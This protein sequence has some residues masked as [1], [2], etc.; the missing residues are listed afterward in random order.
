M[1]LI[2]PIGSMYAIYGNIYHPYTPNVSIYIP[3]MDPMG[4]MYINMYS[5]QCSCHKMFI[6]FCFAC[7]HGIQHLYTYGFWS[8]YTQIYLFYIYIIYLSIINSQDTEKDAS[9]IAN[10]GAVFVCFQVEIRPSRRA[11]ANR[12]CHEL[13]K[14]LLTVCILLTWRIGMA[15]S[16]ATAILLSLNLIFGATAAQE[17]PC[18]HSKLY[19]YIY[20]I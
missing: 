18:W 1:I 9:S 5:S 11:S 8:E 4:M 2:Y 12:R 17:D 14:A 16:I 7:I 15:R 19:T 6:A 3:Y 10:A 20:T 13:P